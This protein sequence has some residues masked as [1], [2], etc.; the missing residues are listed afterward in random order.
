MS[1]SEKHKGGLAVLYIFLG[2]VLGTT[3]RE[4]FE[5]L[6]PSTIV[7]PWATFLINICGALILGFVTGTLALRASTTGSKLFAD[8]FGTGMMGAFTTYGTFVTETDQRYY[9][10][11]WILTATLYGLI[12]I[13][14]GVLAAWC[15][16]AL[17]NLTKPAG[18]RSRQTLTRR[19][20]RA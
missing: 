16:F 9:L 4:L 8:F 19:W 11:G 5:F 6:Q 20:Q 18:L 2:G 15:G 12:S 3:V 7:W 1:F 10:K 14:L 17:A 13:I